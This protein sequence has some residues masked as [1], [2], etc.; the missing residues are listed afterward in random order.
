MPVYSLRMTE[1]S[2]PTS[3]DI[4]N[5]AIRAAIAEQQ[6]AAYREVMAWADKIMGSGWYPSG[7]FAYYAAVSSR[8]VNR[9]SRGSLR[10]HPGTRGT[11]HPQ[12]ADPFHKG[13]E[14]LTGHRHLPSRFSS[15]HRLAFP[16]VPVLPSLPVPSRRERRQR[17]S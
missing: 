2:Q 14:H 17:V 3:Q 1:Q 4:E 11:R 6:N 15:S 12:P 13:C 10:D 16:T 5:A 9:G 7:G 8:R